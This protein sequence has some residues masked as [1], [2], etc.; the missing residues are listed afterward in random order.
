MNS[1]SHKI[2]NGFCSLKL[3][4]IFCVK[5]RSSQQICLN[6]YGLLTNQQ[7]ASQPEVISNN[8][9]VLFLEYGSVCS[10]SYEKLKTLPSY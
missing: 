10:H 9:E 3:A 5:L 7:R 1:T 2:R 4:I 6:R 8:A